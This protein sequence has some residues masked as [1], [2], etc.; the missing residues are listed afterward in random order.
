MSSAF[1]WA[2]PIDPGEQL[3]WFL[4]LPWLVEPFTQRSSLLWTSLGGGL[5]LNEFLSEGSMRP[6]RE[7]NDKEKTNR[8]LK[9]YLTRTT[10]QHWGKLL[11]S[12]V[13]PWTLL[14]VLP[15][16]EGKHGGEQTLSGCEG[17]TCFPEGGTM[18]GEML[19]HLGMA[20]WGPLLGIIQ[21][22]QLSSNLDFPPPPPPPLWAPLNS[23]QMPT[24]A[25]IC[26]SRYELICFPWLQSSSKIR[27]FS[28]SLWI[29]RVW[30]NVGP[31]KHQ[32]SAAIASCTHCHPV[33]L[34]NVVNFPDSLALLSA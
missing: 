16:R 8:E 22:C 11:W 24:K 19:V 17:E 23:I 12:E 27:T 2:W 14:V 25:L 13:N 34:H 28:Y 9:D 7:N 3:V 20:D 6:G 30:P 29:P 15:Q 5:F 18:A 32:L 4:Q 10:H 21:W 33:L 1:C 31:N 26:W